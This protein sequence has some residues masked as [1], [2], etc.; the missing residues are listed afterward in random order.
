MGMDISSI[1]FASSGRYKFYT[2]PRV[3]IRIGK[4][5]YGAIS[6]VTLLRQRLSPIKSLFGPIGNHNAVL[7]RGGLLHRRSI[8]AKISCKYMTP[9]K[10]FFSSWEAPFDRTWQVQSVDSGLDWA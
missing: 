7:R 5:W 9:E 4:S 8:R 10:D 1:H 2:D 6:V 3:D